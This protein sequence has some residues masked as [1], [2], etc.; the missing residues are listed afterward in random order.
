[1]NH[2]F[3]PNQFP[4]DG[5]VIES[6]NRDVVFEVASSPEA[7]LVV[8]LLA[9]SCVV[10]RS[11]TITT[12]T[13]WIVRPKFMGEEYPAGANVR[14]FGFHL[15]LIPSGEHPKTYEKHHAG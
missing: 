11:Q 15:W 8:A 4:I 14:V 10:N 7:A 3:A 9:G 1:M 13:Q 12:V 6:E 2:S 5:E